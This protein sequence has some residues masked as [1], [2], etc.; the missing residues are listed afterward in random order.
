MRLAAPRPLTWTALAFALVLGACSTTVT[1]SSGPVNDVR[2]PARSDNDASRR[3]RTR[4]EL[5]SAY[6]GRGQMKT[7][8]DEVKLALEADP[9]LGAAHNLRGLIHAALGENEQADE[10]FR[11]A[12]ALD[13]L[14]VDALQNYG[15]FLCQRKR[16]DEAEARFAQALGVPS[17]PNAARTWLA[18]G[19]CQLQ[20]GGL[21]AAERSLMRSYELDAGNPTTAFH[22]AEVLLKRGEPERARFY[23]RR[24]NN[25][26]ALVS[27][28]TLWLAARIEHKLGNRSGVRELGEQ[29][30]NRFHESREAVAFQRGQFD[31]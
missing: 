23:I 14:D 16:Y 29:L 22:L 8:L 21:D 27:A 1:T 26:P 2:T 9:R 30:S 13:A 6:F 3:A 7:A 15:W 5:A 19:V 4:L 12:L 25:V 18:Q 20:A 17:N 11:R 24:I 28:Q 31:E 10:S